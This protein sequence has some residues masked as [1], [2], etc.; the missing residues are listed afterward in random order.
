MT[1][2]KIRDKRAIRR[3]AT[4]Q[5]RKLLFGAEVQ[6]MVRY[7]RPVAFLI[8]GWTKETQRRML[9]LMVVADHK[10]EPG[11][12]RQALANLDHFIRTYRINSLIC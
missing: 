10:K 8:V 1:D 11:Y 2:W 7:C 4:T 3:L 9:T 6:I 5:I 12:Q